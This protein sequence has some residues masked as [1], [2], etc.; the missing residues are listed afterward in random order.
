MDAG[1]GANAGGGT[2]VWY[3]RGRV[4]SDSKN[5]EFTAPMSPWENSLRD[6]GNE[7]GET[8]GDDCAMQLSFDSHRGVGVAR[9]APSAAERNHPSHV[10]A[11]TYLDASYALRSSSSMSAKVVHT[12]HG[13]ENVVFFDPD[14]IPGAPKAVQHEYDCVHADS[15]SQR[16][17]FTVSVQSAVLSC[18]RGDHAVVAVSG[19]HCASKTSLVSS[20]SGLIAL[21]AETMFDAADAY[22]S[23]NVGSQVKVHVSWY[24]IDSEGIEDL[25]ASTVSGER[26][27][28]KDMRMREDVQSLPRTQMGVLSLSKAYSKYA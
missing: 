15:S 5:H 21:A 6:E 25:L 1:N 12:Y 9:R 8:H 2:Q 27:T 13:G 7:L 24:A 20:P 26:Q 3:G 19:P 23:T 14:G 16:D 18:T 4:R 17:V 22:K 10:A 11:Y 28:A